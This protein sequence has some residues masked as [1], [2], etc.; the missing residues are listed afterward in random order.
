MKRCAKGNN[1]PLCRL[2]TE[3][4]ELWNVRVRAASTSSSALIVSCMLFP[5]NVRLILFL[6]CGHKEGLRVLLF[7]T[8]CSVRAS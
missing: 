6:N 2:G 7:P 5:E 1:P 8:D 3:S 4:T